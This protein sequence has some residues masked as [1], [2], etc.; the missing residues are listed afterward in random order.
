MSGQRVFARAGFWCGPVHQQLG[1]LRVYGLIGAQARAGLTPVDGHV[2]VLPRCGIR[3]VWQTNDIFQPMLLFSYAPGSFSGSAEQS[4][5]QGEEL[6]LSVGLAIKLEKRAPKQS[7][8]QRGVSARPKRL[9]KARY[10]K[11]K[12]ERKYRA[13]TIP[14]F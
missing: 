6:S 2:H 4:F 8:K 14:N 5:R 12:K 3:P 11:Q 1:H 7:I 9:K 10:K 13:I